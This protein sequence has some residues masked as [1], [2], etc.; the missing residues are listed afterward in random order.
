MSVGTEHG[1]A[2]IDVVNQVAGLTGLPGRVVGK[3]DI[4]ERHLFADVDSEHIHS[5]VAKLNRSELKGHRLK[6]KVA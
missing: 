4:R 3:V 1:V 5:I 6:V 2:P